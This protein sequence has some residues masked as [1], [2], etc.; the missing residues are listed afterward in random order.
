MTVIVS[1]TATIFGALCWPNDRMHYF[2]QPYCKVNSELFFLRHCCRLP[3]VGLPLSVL[4]FYISFFIP[5]T[6]HNKRVDL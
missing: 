3:A 5:L 2:G 1:L 6:F 4:M